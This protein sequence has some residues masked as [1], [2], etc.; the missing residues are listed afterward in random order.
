M[1]RC[2]QYPDDEEMLRQEQK[3]KD[4]S[5]KSTKEQVIFYINQ[6]KKEYKVGL[7]RALS[8]LL[9]VLPLLFQ[10]RVLGVNPPTVCIDRS[11]GCS[12]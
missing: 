3:A 2:V 7:I 8:R 5:A 11:I 10:Y 6:L 12:L 4:V 9:T 1:V